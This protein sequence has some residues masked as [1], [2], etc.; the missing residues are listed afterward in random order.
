MI[1]LSSVKKEV[2]RGQGLERRHVSRTGKHHV[3]LLRARRTRPIEDTSARFAGRA[4]PGVD[5]FYWSGDL[6]SDWLEGNL[7]SSTDCLDSL[8]DTGLSMDG[9]LIDDI[10]Y[11]RC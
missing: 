1:G 8:S 7:V 11:T 5:R 4:P 9:Y 6:S 3:R 10:S 2:C